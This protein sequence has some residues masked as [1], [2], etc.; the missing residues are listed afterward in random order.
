MANGQTKRKVEKITGEWLCRDLEGWRVRVPCQGGHGY[1]SFSEYGGS[2]KAL[3]AARSFQEKALT[4][5]EKDKAYYIKHGEKPARE[6]VNIRN[7]SGHTGICRSVYPNLE[8]RENVAFIATWMVRG[9]QFSKWFST[10]EYGDEKT[11]LKKAIEC[12]AE[13]HNT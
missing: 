1:F 4:Q 6:T 2:H 3:K 5:Y 13:H 7:R 8:G 12:R 10:H 11:A 9:K